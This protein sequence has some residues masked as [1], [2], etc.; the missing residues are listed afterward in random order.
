MIDKYLN[1][2]INVPY[3]NIKKKSFNSTIS[4]II[5]TDFKCDQNETIIDVDEGSTIIAINKFIGDK[6]IV[7]DFFYK[8]ALQTFKENNFKNLKNLIVEPNDNYVYI[9]LSDEDLTQY[10]K[11]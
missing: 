2:E 7:L 1:I 6:L 3:F 8:L 11:K 4:S 10:F 9:G 5:L